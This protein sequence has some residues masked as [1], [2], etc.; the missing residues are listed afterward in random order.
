MSDLKALKK[1]GAGFPP[2][3]RLLTAKDYKKVFANPFKVGT[4]SFTLLATPNTL[5]HARLGL[6]VAKKNVRFAVQRNRIK[7][8]ARDCFRHKRPHLKN[9]DFVILARRG[10]SELP[11][12]L[13]FV[14]LE[15]LWQRAQKKCAGY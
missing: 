14:Q 8:I 3:H 2:A 4:Q 7:R 15:K 5:E 9:Y 11:N 13:L 1:A 6:I 10:S 12:E